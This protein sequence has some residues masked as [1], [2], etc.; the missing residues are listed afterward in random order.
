MSFILFKTPPP[1][2]SHDVWQK[3]YLF[4]IPLFHYYISTD[5]IHIVV[6]IGINKW[7]AKMLKNAEIT[8]TNSSSVAVYYHN[9]TTWRRSALVY[10]NN[11]HVLFFL[12]S[13]FEAY[14]NYTKLKSNVCF[15]FSKEEDK[16]T[17]I[18]FVKRVA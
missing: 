15:E 18:S 3:C 16:L 8:V 13:K 6:R 12:L 17:G 1:P 10:E 5:R 7:L 9:N 14:I 11:V 2:P 4:L